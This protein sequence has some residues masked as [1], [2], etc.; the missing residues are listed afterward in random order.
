LHDADFSFVAAVLG[1]RNEPDIAG[2]VA[3]VV[4]DAVEI[5]PGNVPSRKSLDIPKK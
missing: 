5:K 3:T 4:V 2:N 1:A